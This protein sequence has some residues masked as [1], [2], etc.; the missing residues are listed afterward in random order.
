MAEVARPRWAG[1]CLAT[2]E[3]PLK[4]TDHPKSALEESCA[5]A[6]A[7]PSACNDWDDPL[8]DEV[9]R[10]EQLEVLSNLGRCRYQERDL[11]CSGDSGSKNGQKLW[12]ID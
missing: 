6:S 12:H 5:E 8:E 10:A 4:A 7:D 3:R 2:L 1:E 9:L 11:E